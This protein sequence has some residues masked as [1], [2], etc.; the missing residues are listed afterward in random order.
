MCGQHYWLILCHSMSSTL[1]VS[2]GSRML[3]GNCVVHRWASSWIRKIRL[4]LWPTGSCLTGAGWAAPGELPG[5]L[6]RPTMEGSNYNCLAVTFSRHRGALID[7]RSRLLTEPGASTQ[8]KRL[9]KCSR[10]NLGVVFCQRQESQYSSSWTSLKLF[11][12]DDR[13][14]L[15]MHQIQFS[16]GALIWK[17]GKK[18]R[19]GGR[20][21]REGNGKGKRNGKGKAD[22][23]VIVRQCDFS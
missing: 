5:E 2:T 7:P 1:G 23:T 15:K 8:Y 21:E 3:L 14:S 19:K 6:I 13:F 22:K 12:P 17:K 10:K 11:S 4:A 16:A 9:S 20:G 18:R